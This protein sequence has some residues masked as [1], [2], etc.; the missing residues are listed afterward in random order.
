MHGSSIYGH[1]THVSIATGSNYTCVNDIEIH[2]DMLCD[3]MNDCEDNS[4]E[5][6][7]LCNGKAFTL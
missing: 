4:D 7:T 2:V 5:N 3:G 6:G 1:V